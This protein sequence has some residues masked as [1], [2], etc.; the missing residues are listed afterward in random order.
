MR[1]PLKITWLASYPKSGN[2]MIR[3]FLTAYWQWGR[4]D[5]NG[6]DYCLGDVHPYYYQTVSPRPLED[7]DMKDHVLLRPA[8][9]M[10]LQQVARYQ[11]LLVKTHHIN[12]SIFGTDLI[13]APLTE[14]VIYIVRDPRDIAI[15]YANHFS[16]SID[17]AI[18]SMN[19]EGRHI[20]D[21]IHHHLGTWS[22]H[23]NSYRTA[24]AFKV[25]LVKYEDILKD[26]KEKLGNLLR[27]LGFEVNEERLDLAIEASSFDKLQAQEK[28]KGFNETPH[29]GVTFFRKGTP[30]EWRDVL[31]EEQIEKIQSDHGEVMKSLGYLEEEDADYRT[32]KEG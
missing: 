23:V 5:I 21:D 15:S 1:D 24:K 11:P 2:T 6:L 7:L 29:E 9:L 16:C 28:E 14:Q 4:L 20:G 26:P 18:H 8:S 10:H 3:A 19:D 32:Y 17:D 22:M 31:T 27:Y 12:A 25:G 30:G 13:P